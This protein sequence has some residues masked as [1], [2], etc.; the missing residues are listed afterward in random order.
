MDTEIPPNPPATDVAERA[1]LRTLRRRRRRVWRSLLFILALIPIMIALTVMNRDEAGIDSCWKRMKALQAEFE[2]SSAAARALP[3][4]VPTGLTAGP[5][6]EQRRQLMRFDHYRYNVLF[7]PDPMSG[8]REVGVGCCRRPHA[9]LIGESGR[10]VLVF[11]SQT[12]KFE[13]RWMAEEEFGRRAAELG[14][15]V[16]GER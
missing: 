1:G 8:R 7:H 3:L 15:L 11:D 2:Q 16:Q 14:L 6:A 10:H 13:T 9:R 12:H 4:L 5:E